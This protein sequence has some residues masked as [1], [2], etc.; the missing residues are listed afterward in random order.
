[1]A[2]SNFNTRIFS[3]L[4]QLPFFKT[5]LVSFN[6]KVCLHYNLKTISWVC[7]KNNGDGHLKKRF[8]A[9]SGLL[10]RFFKLASDSG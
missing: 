9:I 2:F 7:S 3:T 10:V 4:K 8:L 1:M 6:I 5:K